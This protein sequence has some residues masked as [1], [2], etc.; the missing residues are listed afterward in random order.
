[1][2]CQTYISHMRRNGHP[3]LCMHR[4][5]FII[6]SKLGWLG[7]SPDGRVTDPS[8]Q[9]VNGIIEF[10]W[11]YAYGDKALQEA[12]KDEHF[13]CGLNGNGTIFLK[14]THQYHHQVQLWLFV[15]PDMLC[16]RGVT[17]I[18]IVSKK[19]LFSIFFQI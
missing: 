13:Y 7:A 8:L 11:F 9:C 10:K 14:V 1:M 15:G 19:S 12:C 17:F 4:C 3:D 18:F 2:A 5:G 16:L 6:H